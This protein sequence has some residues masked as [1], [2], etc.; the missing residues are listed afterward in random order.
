MI[1]QPPDSESHFVPDENVKNK[2]LTFAEIQE[3][4]DAIAA[5]E[6]PEH[7]Q[8][9]ITEVRQELEVLN[10]KKETANEKYYVSDR[11]WKHILHLV[12]TSAYLHG[13][14]QA[15]SM[16]ATL[17]ADCI[18]NTEA[19]REEVI[20]IIEKALILHSSAEATSLKDIT[21]QLNRFTDAVNNTWYDAKPAAPIITEY[22]GKTCYEALG[23][24]GKD[25]YL[26][27]PEGNQGFIA[28]YAKDSGATKKVRI[29]SAPADKK[30]L[31]LDNDG[32]YTLR[33]HE[34]ADFTTEFTPKASGFDDT[35]VY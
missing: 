31:V 11:W 18:W 10:A 13:R 6:I 32:T 1:K 5:V 35:E 30:T 25:Y 20:G 21:E 7:I 3:W 9:F 22:D 4:Q 19:Q 8:H 15:D 16:D 26:E 14:K 27:V 12:R 24:D 23:P 34:A 29:E 17:I 28:K 33:W 2:L